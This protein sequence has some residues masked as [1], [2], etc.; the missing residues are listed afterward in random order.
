[1]TVSVLILC[2]LTPA[3]LQ[4]TWGQV[5]YT[6]SAKI[7]DSESAGF[8]RQIAVTT[9]TTYILHAEGVADSGFVDVLLTK[10]SNHSLRIEDKTNL[11]AHPG[12][13]N[14]YQILQSQDGQYIYVLW[15][16]DATGSTDIY[17][18]RSVDHGIT[19]EEPL[20][21]SNDSM[22]SGFA[23]M[24]VSGSYVYVVWWDVSPARSEITFV[25]ST[26]FG[27][28]FSDKITLTEDVGDLSF[29]A[30]S[31]SPLQI[32]ANGRHV[33]VS[34]HVSQTSGIFLQT[35]ADSGLT[36]DKPVDLTDGIGNSRGYQIIAGESEVYA[37]WDT[38]KDLTGDREV[39]FS[40][41]TDNGIS[42]SER[43]RLSDDN[44]S[45]DPVMAVSGG[46][47]YVAWES[48]VSGSGD[49]NVLFSRSA[50]GGT[51]FEPPTSI[52]ETDLEVHDP[53]IIAIQNYVSLAWRSHNGDSENFRSDTIFMT[54][55]DRG[56]SF[57]KQ[58]RVNNSHES[59]NHSLNL[60]ESG[61]IVLIWEELVD[62]GS[63]AEVYFLTA[64][65]DIVPANGVEELAQTGV[66]TVT[67]L[68]LEIRNITSG[69]LDDEI[70][71]QESVALHTVIVNN[72]SALQPYVLIIE[73]RNELGITTYL[74][75]QSGVLS[76]EGRFDAGFS[77]K[78]EEKGKYEIRSLAISDLQEPTLISGLSV[79]DVTVT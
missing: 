25:R 15:A 59:Q 63:S 40:K 4:N 35:S 28:S 72:R 37:I 11:S 43:I 32:C 8:D 24:A 60:S 46:N 31:Q 49:R 5:T 71:I 70:A 7:F 48:Y 47:V 26:N 14:P 55:E 66:R 68:P 42:F 65:L 38:A 54:S 74:Q 17:I 36:F 69:K 77:W 53:S 50:N 45:T 18:R 76:L 73:V 64:Q 52:G 12:S 22:F 23:Q 58:I 19:F 51:S 21:L 78:P 67:V 41:S 20:N 56:Q 33:Y 39:Y 34:W 29:L 57:G 9:D 2:Q 75:Y 27:E 6:Q 3:F 61:R 30:G 79:A 10:V 44:G 1:V 13:G 62:S 16:D